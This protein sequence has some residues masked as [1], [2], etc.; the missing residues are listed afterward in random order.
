MLRSLIVYV[1]DILK[2]I[3]FSL[4]F[5]RHSLKFVPKCLIDKKVNIK[6]STLILVKARCCQSGTL[7]NF[8]LS[9]K[10]FC[11]IH[12]R[13]ISPE[14][15]MNFVICDR[16]CTFKITVTSSLSRIF[17]TE[18][19][20][21]TTLLSQQKCAPS[22]LFLAEFHLCYV[23]TLRLVW[24]SPNNPMLLLGGLSCL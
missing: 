16:D 23:Q 13:A 8:D 10:L 7:T 4:Y 14:V 19:V 9:S 17:W 24:S 12:L 21:L 22:K 15:P 6:K 18:W 11:G 20:T 3:D 1:S 5:D 2:H